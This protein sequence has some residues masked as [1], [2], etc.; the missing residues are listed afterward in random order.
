LNSG[1]QQQNDATMDPWLNLID[2]F[3]LVETLSA[4]IVTK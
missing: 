1:P 2:E 3:E 4:R